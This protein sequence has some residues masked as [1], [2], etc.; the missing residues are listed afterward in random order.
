VQAALDALPA[1]RWEAVVAGRAAVDALAAE[2]LDAALRVLRGADGAS[3][4]ARSPGDDP[5][6]AC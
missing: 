5:A 6:G 4:G 1:E 2:A 3:G